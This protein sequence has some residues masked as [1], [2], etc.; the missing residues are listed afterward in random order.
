M[1]EQVVDGDWTL[2]RNGGIAGIFG[3]EG[4]QDGL[5]GE[6]RDVF[7]NGIVK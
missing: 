4:S 3:V 7:G 2:S 6:G 1:G 5:M